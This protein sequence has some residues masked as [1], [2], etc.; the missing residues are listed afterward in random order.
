MSDP[1]GNSSF[2][3]PESPDGLEGPHI[4]C[5][6]IFLDLHFNSN[7]RI[8][9]ANQNSW[10][11]TYNNTNLILKTTEWMIYKQKY[12]PYVICIFFLH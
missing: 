2:C 11:G 5:F 9:R 10:L 12:F 3:F 8:T 4:K 1:N 7:Y 6:V